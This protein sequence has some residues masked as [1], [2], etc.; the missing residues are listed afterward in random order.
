[1]NAREAGFGYVI[2][3]PRFFSSQ[4]GDVVYI[5]EEGVLRTTGSMFDDTYFK[6][7]VDQSPHT[8]DHT[9]TVEEHPSM[10]VAFTTGCV[11]VKPLSEE[12]SSRYLI[13]R[14]TAKR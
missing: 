7:L 8:M 2:P 6:R 1:M 3:M 5:D 4:L 9:N 12:E 13:W 11:D 14:T 10:T